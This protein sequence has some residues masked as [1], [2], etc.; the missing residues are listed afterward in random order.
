[1][2]P[3]TATTWST[4]CWP[5]PGPSAGPGGPE[6]LAAYEGPAAHPLTPVGAEAASGLAESA[7]GRGHRPRRPSTASAGRDRRPGVAEAAE[8]VRRGTDVVLVVDPDAA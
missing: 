1:M 3:R 7:S 6:V 2:T 5:T 8:L 4:G